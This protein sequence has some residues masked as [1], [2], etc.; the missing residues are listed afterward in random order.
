MDKTIV[1][2]S[3]FLL[4]GISL[5]I[6][7]SDKIYKSHLISPVSGGISKYTVCIHDPKLNRGFVVS[8]KNIE[9]LK[10]IQ[11]SLNNADKHYI[12]IYNNGNYIL[13]NRIHKREQITKICD[14]SNMD[15]IIKKNKTKYIDYSV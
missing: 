5:Y 12:I 3:I 1:I 6:L 9:E 14:Y 10:T 11:N 8:L 13:L 4:I 2:V 15:K 7:S